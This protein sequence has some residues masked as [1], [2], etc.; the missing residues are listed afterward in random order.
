MKSTKLILVLF[1]LVGVV[2]SFLPRGENVAHAAETQNGEIIYPTVACDAKQITMELAAEYAVVGLLGAANGASQEDVN[3]SFEETKIAC[4]LIGGIANLK[5]LQTKAINVKGQNFRCAKFAERKTGSM[6]Y[7]ACIM[8][9]L[10][11]PFLKFENGKK[12]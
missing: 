9:N 4:R 12:W 1:L 2:V 7:H 11:K 6:E 3:S 8:T 10:G 5:I